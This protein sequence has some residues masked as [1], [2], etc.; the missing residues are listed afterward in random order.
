MAK[1]QTAARPVT[2]GELKSIV[3][4]SLAG[5]A[6]AKSL[7]LQLTLRDAALVK[8]SPL[9]AESDIRF[10]DGAMKVLGVRTTI[11]EVAES[12]LVDAASLPK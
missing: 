1:P 4:A 3:E 11:G 12:S 9:F 8:R 10:A 6:K 2:V 7:V 5:G